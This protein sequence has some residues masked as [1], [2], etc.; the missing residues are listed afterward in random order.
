MNAEAHRNERS[1]RDKQRV[2][3]RHHTVQPS[4]QDISRP[5]MDEIKRV[6]H[7]AKQASDCCSPCAKHPADLRI[8]LD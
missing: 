3:V 5:L 7:Q 1:Q 6:R 8:E 2:L 4:D